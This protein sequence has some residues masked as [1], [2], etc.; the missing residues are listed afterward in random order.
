MAL[1]SVSHLEKRFNL[2]AGFFARFGRFV[3]A[4]NDLSFAIGKNES[5]GL[6]GESGCGKTTTAR[7]LVRMY[8][9]DGGDILFQDR[10][11]Q[12]RGD[13]DRIDVRSLKK[14]E[15]KAYREKV[16]YIFQDPARSLNPRMNVYEVL[17]SGCRRSAALRGL[18]E[19]GLREE[20]AAILAEVG[21]NRADLER[22]SQ[23]FSGGQRQRISIARGLLVKPELLICDEVV[24]ALDVSIQ[25]QILNLLLDLRSKRDLSFLFI[26]HD[27]KVAC[28][29][30]DRIG[31]M[32][33]G[34]LMEE[35]PAAELYRTGLHP[36]TELL[37][38]SVAGAGADSVQA[39]GPAR[40]GGAAGNL[41]GGGTG[42]RAQPGGAARLG[43]GTGGQAADEGSRGKGCSF[44]GRCPLAS[45]Q[46]FSEHPP[47][48]EAA[49]GHWIRCFYR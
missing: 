6:V 14:A 35:A 29:F 39:G 2:E 25:G 23:E 24:S 32:Y 15:L 40:L 36:Y 28:Y 19:K 9:A 17:V 4:V 13:L 38:S 41:G 44:A 12:D 3:Y 37:F 7:L 46:C 31:V 22:R 30:C 18:G 26:A 33:R 48:R 45:E 11:D 5:Y 49:R 8:E 47:L 21:L 16:R 27:L 43:D 34:E 42:G 20:A 10:G 1:I